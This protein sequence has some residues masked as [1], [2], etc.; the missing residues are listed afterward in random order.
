MALT[1][2]IVSSPLPLFDSLTA[3]R[4]YAA[5]LYADDAVAACS[6]VFVALSW[7]PVWIDADG[8]VREAMYVGASDGLTWVVAA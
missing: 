1:G 4:G 5:A 7:G 3:A 6:V 8:T 2:H